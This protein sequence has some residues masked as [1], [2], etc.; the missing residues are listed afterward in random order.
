[1]VES[2]ASV[3]E[4]KELSAEYQHFRLVRSE[5]AYVPEVLIVTPVK[6]ALAVVTAKSK[7]YNS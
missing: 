1:M 2:K 6:V 3:L 4:L 7:R 5:A